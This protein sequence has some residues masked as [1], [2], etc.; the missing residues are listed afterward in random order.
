MLF[1]L[2]WDFGTID[3][4]MGRKTKGKKKNMQLLCNSEYDDDSSDIDYASA[5]GLINNSN[6]L[7][8]QHQDGS[9]DLSN[10]ES[11][12]IKTHNQ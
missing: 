10:G 11:S 8:N 1:G 3:K 5:N 9:N 2:N 4:N 6:E 12:V 7:R